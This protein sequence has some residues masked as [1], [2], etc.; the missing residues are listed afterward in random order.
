[1]RAVS[2][3]FPQAAGL[4]LRLVVAEGNGAGD[5]ETLSQRM[6]LA[7]TPAGNPVEA[8][9]FLTGGRHWEQADRHRRA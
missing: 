2:Q 9:L 5:R 7:G 1:M 3:K 8:C 6:R 4:G